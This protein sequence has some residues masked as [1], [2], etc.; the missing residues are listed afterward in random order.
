[1][2][3]FEEAVVRLHVKQYRGPGLPWCCAKFTFL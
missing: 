2:N 1:M 3:S